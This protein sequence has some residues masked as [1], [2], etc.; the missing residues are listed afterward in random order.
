[1]VCK[2]ACSQKMYNS[3]Y[4]DINVN[5]TEMMA[6]QNQ[7][8]VQ[9]WHSA[10]WDQVDAVNK[11][12]TVEFVDFLLPKCLKR[13]ISQNEVH[14]F[15]F[16]TPHKIEYWTQFSTVIAFYMSAENKIH[17]STHMCVS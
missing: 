16:K 2:G 10:T 1:M 11:L 12:Q 7:P 9:L 3:I 13:V 6:C 15:M 17:C 14:I 5:L 4:W 8:H